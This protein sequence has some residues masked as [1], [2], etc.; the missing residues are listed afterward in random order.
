[1]SRA[2]VSN[3]VRVLAADPH[4]LYLEALA[5]AVRQCAELQLVGEVA[6]G[7]AA[8]AWILEVLPDVAVLGAGLPGL[9]G[10]RVLRALV[11]DRTG[12]RVVLLGED[13]A[14]DAI[15]AGAA[16]CLS[17]CATSLQICDAVRRVARGEVVIA[18]EV[19]SAVAAGIRLRE[20]AGEALLT[21]REREILA[22]VA[23][24]MTAPEIGSS[25]HLGRATV[26]THMRHVYEKLGVSN[27]PAAVAQGMR[28]G[29]LE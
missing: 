21:V 4:P 19:Q 29:L 26:K 3:P 28:R 14:Y 6:N 20:Q 12:T 13:R 5:R 10:H 23:R 7:R 2:P 16:G 18:R 8:L 24:G 25:L 27:G 1:M 22:L 17:K 11:R 9:D 15:A